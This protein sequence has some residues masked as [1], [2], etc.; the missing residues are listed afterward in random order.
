[1]LDKENREIYHED[2]ETRKEEGKDIIETAK[3]VKDDIVESA[4][5]AIEDAKENFRDFRDGVHEEVRAEDK[6]EKEY[7]EDTE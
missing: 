2:K 5:S 7:L 6:A 4:K 3:D 1:M